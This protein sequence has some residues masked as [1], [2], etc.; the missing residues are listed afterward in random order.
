M[1]ITIVI[2]DTMDRFHEYQA[3][4]T[5]NQVSRRAVDIELKQSQIKEI[6]LKEGESIESISLNLKS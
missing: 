6:G 2:N 1:K 4:G 5:M 3:T